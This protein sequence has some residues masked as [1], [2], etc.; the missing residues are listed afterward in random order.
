MPLYTVEL[1][2]IADP[3]IQRLLAY[4]RQQPGPVLLVGGCVRDL[5]LGRQTRDLDLVVP[6]RGLELA[7]RV[8]DAFGGAFVPVDPE[9]DVGRAVLPGPGG[10]RTLVDIAAWRAGSLEEDLAL[11]D[12]TIN[13]LAVPVG[14]LTPTIV[15]VTGGLT[16]LENRV[17]R[18]PSPQAFVDD[19]LRTLRAVRLQA[20]LAPWGFRLDAGTAEQVRL[21]AAS[22]TTCSAERM[23]DELVRILASESPEQWLR[24]LAD[25]DLLPFVL[26]E[27]EALRGVDQS[28]PQRWDVFEHTLRTVAHV[29][30]LQAWLQRDIDVADPADAQLLDLLLPFRD[31]LA[32]Y[33]FAGGGVELRTPAHLVRWAALCHDWGKPGARQVAFDGPA[34]DTQI[35]FLGYEHLS[36]KLTSSALRRLRFSEEAVRRTSSIVANHLRPLQLAKEPQAPSARTVYRYFRDLGDTGV[37]VALLSVSGFRATAAESWDPET[38]QRLLRVV[39]NLLHDYFDRPNEAVALPALI[40]GNDLMDSLGLAPGRMVGLLLEAVAE[41]QAAGEVH[42][43]QEAL[44]LAALLAAQFAAGG[45]SAN[46]RVAS[47]AHVPERPGVSQ[48]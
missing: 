32:A 39:A 9:R 3:T 18:A 2:T 28:L 35:Q 17:L 45:T 19:P 42:S 30:W 25:V 16:D 7:R 38:W 20:E 5:L 12:L 21:H 6:A 27:V 4:F 26:P 40:D 13:A 11:R 37:D 46:G 29:A 34:S 43:A 48:A 10:Q 22:L 23:R 33:W 14:G 41:A 31:R 8:A 36:A 44:A 15:D 24:L 47:K 1:G